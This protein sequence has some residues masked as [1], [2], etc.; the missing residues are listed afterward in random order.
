MSTQ[1]NTIIIS[2]HHQG[3]KLGGRAYVQNIISTQPQGDKLGGREY[4]EYVQNIISTQPQGDK[5]GGRAYVE[6]VLKSWDK[7]AKLEKPKHPSEELIPMCW[8]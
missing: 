5:L 2:T 7:L 3:D 6:M 8:Q 4:R 1:Q